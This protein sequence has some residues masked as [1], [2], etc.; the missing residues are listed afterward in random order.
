MI[1]KVVISDLELIEQLEKDNLGHSLG[2][3]FLHQELTTNPF[4]QMLVYVKAEKLIGY[5]SYRVTDD[6]AECL[7]IVIA[8]AYQRQG[9]GFKLLSY[10]TQDLEKKHV[11]SMILEVGTS[12]LA[13]QY[14]YY[15]LGFKRILVRPNYYG[16]ED[17]YVFLWER[18][19]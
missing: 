6:L 9:Y 7:N 10:V 3:Q 1:R 19:A 18:E 16:H 4:S 13:A 15:K 8:K 17:A 11:K 14:L 5:I 12:N 2:Y